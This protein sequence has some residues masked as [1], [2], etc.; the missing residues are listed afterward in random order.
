LSDR[1]VGVPTLEERMD[2]VR[3]VMD[4]VGSQRAAIFGHSEGGPMSMLF[5]ATYPERTSQL[6]L[7][8]TMA[9]FTRAPDYPWGV[10]PESYDQL[11]SG[12]TAV[13]GSVDSP[14][15]MIFAPSVAADAGFREWAARYERQGA[16]PGAFAAL[17][18]MN[19]EIDVRHVLASIHVPTLVLHRTGD[20]A[21]PVEQGRYVAARID[22]ARFVELEG[23]DHFMSVGNADKLLDEVED[24]L[25]GVRG[26]AE[27]DRVL[28]TVLFADIVESTAQA[29]ALGD[30]RWRALLDRHDAVAHE[31][32]ER[33]RG[34]L[35]KSTGDGFLATFDGPARAIRSACA[36]RDA[37]RPL[38]LRIRAGLHTGECELRG[39]D[40][41]G[42]A[43]HIGSRVAAAAGPDEIFVS[44]TV[45]DLV[46]GAS[47][48]FADRGTRELKG[49]PGEWRLYAVDA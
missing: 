35:V 48:R 15:P 9:K 34:R 13:W 3:A 14:T 49:V 29:A 24:F 4:A 5:A 28:A 19:A 36:V 30:M 17:M 45:K 6:V 21:V 16:S 1:T 31:V 47:L 44:S 33:Y 20:A 7:Y 26:G 27:P 32:I 2:D 37:V 39:G 8:G 41:A 43:V 46:A 42:I 25:T 12:L 11:V 22:G 23:C 18:R 10:P 40:L 38:G